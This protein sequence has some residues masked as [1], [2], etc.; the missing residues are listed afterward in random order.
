[1]T[2][3][4]AGLSSRQLN[5]TLSRFSGQK[6]AGNVGMMDGLLMLPKSVKEWELVYLNTQFDERPERR[7]IRHASRRGFPP[8]SLML[9][10][11]AL[12]T[13]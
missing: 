4:I 3:Q 8:L 12:Y 5:E 6:E 2:D 7:K 10:A 11:Q 9:I 13:R 1:M